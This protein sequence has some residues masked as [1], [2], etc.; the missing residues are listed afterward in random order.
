MSSSVDIWQKRLKNR[1][2]KPLR[3]LLGGD[4]LAA[5][6]KQEPKI[7]QL[8]RRL[9]RELEGQLEEWS[10]LQTESDRFKIAERLSRAVYPK[11]KFNDITRICLEDKEF[12][13]YYERFMEGQNWHSYERKYFQRELLKLALRAPGH[14]AECGC[15]KGATAYL[16]CEA[17]QGEDRRVHLFDSF[18]GLS[19][20]GTGDGEHWTQGALAA[21]L[22]VVAD[23]LSEFQCWKAYPGW[24]PTRFDEVSEER[25]A[26][27]HIDVDLYEPTRDAIEFFYPR[28]SPG[29]VMLLDDHGFGTCPGAKCAADEFFQD[30]PE[31]ILLVPNG[32]AFVIRDPWGGLPSSNGGR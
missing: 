28:L 25:F 7:P 16:L 8:D 29:G 24:I 30:R 15:Y 13:A 23:A 10:A 2:A 4:A 27:V 9:L 19:E 21:P 31:D 17:A 20:P 14:F 22:E 11:Y 12:L 32:Q 6:D 3:R 18:E 26:F 5:P 1:V